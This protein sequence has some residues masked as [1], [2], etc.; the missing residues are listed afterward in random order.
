MAGT[1]NGTTCPLAG[2]AG[3][4]A[5][6]HAGRPHRAGFSLT[7]GEFAEPD[8]AASRA[9]LARGAYASESLRRAERLDA[10]AEAVRKTLR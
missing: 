10:A 7:P 3:R 5:R 2:R 6:Q 8:A 1:I 4:R 9:G